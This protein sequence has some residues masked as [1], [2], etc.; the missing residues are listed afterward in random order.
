MQE[1]KTGRI[2]VMDFGLAR[3]MGGDGMTQTGALLGTIEYMSP[4]QSMGKS[5]DQRSRYFR[6]GIDFLRIAGGQDAVQ[7]GYGDG[8]PVAAESGARG[9]CGGP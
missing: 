4:E 7:S 2:L 1:A 8:Q 9:A 3:T 6:G 5:L